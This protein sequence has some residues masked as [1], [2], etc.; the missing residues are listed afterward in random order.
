MLIKTIKKQL[1]QEIIFLKTVF[2]A[3]FVDS[4]K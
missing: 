2:Y 4:Y 1:L 3:I